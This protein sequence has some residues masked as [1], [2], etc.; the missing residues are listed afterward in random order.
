MNP[1]AVGAVMFVVECVLYH[2]RWAIWSTGPTFRYLQVVYTIV[3]ATSERSIDLYVC[4]NNIKDKNCSL[5][6]VLTATHQKLQKNC[7]NHK[8]VILP[9][10]TSSKC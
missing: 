8:K 10:N 2:S 5:S 3:I 1:V 9:T 4:Y 6:I 7:K